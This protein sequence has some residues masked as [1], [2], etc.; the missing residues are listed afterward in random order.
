MVQKQL[1]A[2]DRL[3]FHH[4]VVLY[5]DCFWPRAGRHTA[6]KW[7]LARRSNNRVQSAGA[8]LMAKHSGEPPAH[9]MLGRQGRSVPGPA[10]AWRPRSQPPAL[11]G[12]GRRPP[13][14]QPHGGPL[15]QKVGVPPSLTLADFSFMASLRFRRLQAGGEARGYLQGSGGGWGGRGGRPRTQPGRGKGGEGGG[16]VSGGASC[17]A[18]GG[19]RRAGFQRCITQQPQQQKRQKGRRLTAWPAAPSG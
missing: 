18:S 17:A 6:K 5:T 11:Q 10:C 8:V 13:V 1:A 14:R 16:L 4:A 3:C 7:Y 19:Q 12:A 9:G 15:L 2:H